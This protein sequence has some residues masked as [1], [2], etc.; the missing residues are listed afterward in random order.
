M[1]ESVVRLWENTTT[2]SPIA[3]Q[4][5]IIWR[6]STILPPCSIDLISRSLF[7][8]R[9]ANETHHSSLPLAHFSSVIPWSTSNVPSQ[10][11]SCASA[12]SRVW[13]R[14]IWHLSHIQAVTEGNPSKLEWSWVKK[15]FLFYWRTIFLRSNAW[16]D[17]YSRRISILWGAWSSLFRSN[18]AGRMVC[19]WA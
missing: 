11:S 2:L 10:V 1:Y 15:I 7:A 14:A 13:N 3:S 9:S 18:Q 17:I 8:A 16:F 4:C 19:H 6:S 12:S 5:A